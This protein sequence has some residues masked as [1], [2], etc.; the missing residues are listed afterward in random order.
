MTIG[1]VQSSEALS[2]SG[3]RARE[4]VEGV[5][6]G[7]ISLD[8]EWRITDCN[9]GA[10]RL[11]R[12]E[13]KDLLGLRLWS[14]AGLAKDSAFAE[15]GRRVALRRRPE[16]A[17]F[18]YRADRR[19]RLL[20]I[21]AFPLAGG[22]A[23]AWRDIT[24]VRASER[25]LA[26]SESHQ[27]EVAA[28]L[29]A[30]AW[31]SRSD[32]QL[33]FINEAMA[34]A[35]GRPRD[36]LLGEGWMQS[37]DPD[38]RLGLEITRMQART[39]AAPVQYEGKFRRPDGSV[40]IIQLYGRPRFDRSGRFSG[41][42]GVAT[43]VTE[44][45]AA[46]ARQRL[47]IN[48]LNHRVKNALA[49]V[50]ALVRQ[51]LREHNASP[52]LAAALDGRIFALAAA[53]DVLTREKWVGAEVGAIAAE[54]TKPYSE[55]GAFSFSGPRAKIGPKAAVAL[56]MALHELSTNALKYGSLSSPAGRVSLTWSCAGDIVTLEWRESGGPPAAPPDRSG[57][58][59]RLLGR[60]LEGE[61]G[62]PA[63]LDFAPTGLLCRIH[64]PLE[65]S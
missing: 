1:D 55:D 36:E 12:Q 22:V 33:I 47:L 48:E 52:E 58:G 34:Q 29:P 25:R 45:R 54:A 15:L 35:L 63:E 64:A 8:A 28:D 13:R 51:T 3:S 44:V 2:L 7:F 50:Q 57:F 62:A 32:G 21:R 59:L 46:E 49:T 60:V 27:R 30:A 56:S 19:T 38:D 17:E 14:V 16:E 5:A 11:L 31:L 20:L 42:V 39:N 24:K 9:A 23:A 6:D 41:H 65:T 61:L 37:I 26:A 40:R 4:I 10:A 18:A 53:H 43:D